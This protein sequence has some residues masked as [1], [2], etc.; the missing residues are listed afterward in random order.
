MLLSFF[1]RTTNLTARQAD[2]SGQKHI[3]GGVYEAELEKLTQDI[4]SSL[5]LIL[6]GYKGPKVGLDF[7]MQSSP[8]R[9]R[10]ETKR[11]SLIVSEI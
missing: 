9:R 11:C 1:Y 5:P 10:F 7:R 6:Q 8:S 3:R 2:H 4:S